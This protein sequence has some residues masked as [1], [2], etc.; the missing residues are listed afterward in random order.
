MSMSLRPTLDGL[1][2]A[3]TVKEKTQG[4]KGIWIEHSDVLPTRQE[5]M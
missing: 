3:Y 1:P 4:S 2:V 5:S